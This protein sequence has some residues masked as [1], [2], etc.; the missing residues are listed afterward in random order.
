MDRNYYVFIDAETDGLYGNFLTVAIL[1]LDENMQEKERKYAGIKKENLVVTDLWTKENVLP[2]LAGYEECETE[3]E[4]LEKIWGIWIKYAKDA[5]AIAD[6][7]YPVE[8]RLFEKCVKL[9]EHERKFQAPY[10]LIDLSSLLLAKGIDPLKERKEMVDYLLD[11]EQHNAMYDVET[12]V[13][14][15]KKLFTKGMYDEEKGEKLL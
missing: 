5:Y 10:P 2:V 9:N 6:V 3:K 4:L 1:V 13:E 12:M 7:C 14:I 8:C 11:G 15:W